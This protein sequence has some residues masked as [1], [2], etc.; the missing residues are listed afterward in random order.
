MTKQ[1]STGNRQSV[2]E[3]EHA[4]GVIRTILITYGVAASSYLFTQSVPE[5]VGPV[6]GGMF[7]PRSLVVLG[8]AMQ[9][10]MIGARVLI[11]RHAPDSGTAAQGMF[12][13]ELIGDG[14]TVLFF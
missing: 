14:V 6:Y 13:L 9:V 2:F 8:L 3:K 5:G 10:L 12:I 4:Y 11:K 1:Y 7:S